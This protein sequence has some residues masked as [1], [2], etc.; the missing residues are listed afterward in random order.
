MLQCPSQGH[1]TLVIHSSTLVIHSFL[2]QTLTASNSND[3]YCFDPVAN[4][5]STLWVSGGPSGRVRMGF[6]AD[7]NNK[8]YVFGGYNDNDGEDIG[9]ARRIR[10]ESHHDIITILPRN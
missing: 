4:A 5:W 7:S 8:L 9:A 10:H 1:C 2:F 6:T 3:L